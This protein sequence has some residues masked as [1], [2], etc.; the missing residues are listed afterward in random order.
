M[1]LGS[2]GIAGLEL[3]AREGEQSY[4]RRSRAVALLATI[5]SPSVINTLILI[6]NDKD[7]VYRCFAIQ[8][9][10]E[11][12]STE[13]TSVLIKKLDDRS[14]CMQMNATDPARTWPVYV[15]DEAVRALESQTGLSFGKTSD[16]EHRLTKPW[17]DWWQQK[18]SPERR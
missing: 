14:V 18:A 5:D 16:G 13:R 9:L 10:A 4:L 17:K 1:E 15:A 12:K 7:P 8:A 3:I 11:V 6:T 2:E